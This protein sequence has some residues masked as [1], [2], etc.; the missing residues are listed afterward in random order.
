MQINKTNN[1]IFLKEVE[2]NVIQE[3]IVILK[4]NIKFEKC[5][6][7]EKKD[8]MSNK[9]IDVLK[10]AELIVNQELTKHNLKYEQYK[11]IRLER[12]LKI[13][14]IFSI[15]NVIIFMSYILIK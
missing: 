8:Q 10:E 11:I 13:L 1:V 12:K 5:Q 14:K 2:S 3:A 7:I 4:D 15:I 6:E 9:N